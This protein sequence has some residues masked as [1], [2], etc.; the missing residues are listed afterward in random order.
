MIREICLSRSIRLICAGGL[1]AGILSQPALAQE[2]GETAGMQRVEV[3]GSSIK[4]LV[5]ETATPLSI[6]K[7]EDFAKQGPVS[8]THLTLPTTPY[9]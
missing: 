6:F 5:S 2:T 7:A 4:R 1:A 8:Y 3:T 9:V